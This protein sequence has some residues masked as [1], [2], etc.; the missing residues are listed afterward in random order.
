MAF[1][2]LHGKEL[3]IVR[4]TALDGL[5]SA[6]GGHLTWQPPRLQ[7]EAPWSRVA[8]QAREYLHAHLHE[9]IGLEQ[10]A[11]A[12]GE[13]RFVVSRAFKAEFGLPPHAYLIQ[14][15]LTRAREGLALGRTP[16]AVA[17]DLGFADQSHLGR[18]F[19][20]AYQLTPAHYRR[21]CTNL[22]D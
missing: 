17:A 14:L 22:P 5:L 15:K 6:L 3:R 13:S 2:A 18:W 21:L 10:L 19:R 1:Q 20:R 8:H 7:G 12:T 16:A 9:D 11:A 4:Q